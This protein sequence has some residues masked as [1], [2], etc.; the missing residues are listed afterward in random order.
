MVERCAG[1][2]AITYEKQDEVLKKGHRNGVHKYKTYFQA[3]C[4]YRLFHSSVNGYSI[5]LIINIETLE[6]AQIAITSNHAPILPALS[7]NG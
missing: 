1:S 4:D 2:V 6:T 7:P 3:G 5:K